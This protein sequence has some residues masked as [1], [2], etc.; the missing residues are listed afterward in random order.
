[1]KRFLPL[2]VFVIVVMLCALPLLRGHDPKIVPS[3]LVGQQA[4]DFK[5]DGL[6]RG[7]LAGGAAL[8]NFFASWC[9]PCVAEQEY[10]T[11]LATTGIRVFGISYKDKPEDTRAF[12]KKHGNPFLKTGFDTRGR[13]AIDWGVSGV[14]ETFVLDA[15]GGVLYRH[16]GVLTPDVFA[17][18]I[19]PLLQGGIR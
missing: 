18:K 4:P 5:I 2:G 15:K 3:A 8:V 12:L 14:P 13:V 7:D 9:T 1:M 11:Q 19:A 16:T 17:E 10:L 6:S